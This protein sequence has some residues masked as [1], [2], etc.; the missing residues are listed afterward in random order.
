MKNTI[1][2]IALKGNNI[3]L[4]KG[5]V[6]VTPPMHFKSDY[7]CAGVKFLLYEED[8][9][10]IC[11]EVMGKMNFAWEFEP[12]GFESRIVEENADSHIEEFLQKVRTIPFIDVT[13]IDFTLFDNLEDQKKMAVATGFAKIKGGENV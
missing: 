6:V 2:E 1:R 8:N 9:E 12:S 4:I 3:K 7:P 11:I 13:T 5:I 10:R